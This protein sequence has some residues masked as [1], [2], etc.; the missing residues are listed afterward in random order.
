MCI[1][2]LRQETVLYPLRSGLHFVCH[3]ASAEAQVLVSVFRSI[4]SHNL[5]L[6]FLSAISL[7]LTSACHTWR[8]PLDGPF[9]SLPSHQGSSGIREHPPSKSF[10]SCLSVFTP[11]FGKASCDPSGSLHFKC[12]SSLYLFICIWMRLFVLVNGDLF[13]L[14][15]A[16]KGEQKTQ[17]KVIAWLQLILQSH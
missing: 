5:R 4:A 16:L 3:H 11:L 12:C 9:I 13:I 6:S 10:S 1:S 2:P 7:S 15:R 8:L 17:N 14:Y